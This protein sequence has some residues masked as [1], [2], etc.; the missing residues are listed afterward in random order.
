MNRRLVSLLLLTSVAFTAPIA[1]AAPE[2]ETKTVKSAPADEAQAPADSTV[3]DE[4]IKDT[5]LDNWGNDNIS[6][7][8]QPGATNPFDTIVPAIATVVVPAAQNLEQQVSTVVQ[9]VTADVTAAAQAAAPV[10]QNL[11][12]QAVVVAQN[13]VA[14]VESAAQAAAPVIQSLEQQAVVVAQNVAT[15][16][17]SAIS[18]VDPSIIPAAQNLAQQAVVVAQTT[19]ATVVTD[20]QSAINSAATAVA[21]ATAT[22][23][24]SSIDATTTTASNDPQLTLD[25]VVADLSTSDQIALLT[26]LNDN[27]VSTPSDAS[28]VVDTVSTAVTNAET[29]ATTAA[30]SAEQA[31]EAAYATVASNLPTADQ[32]QQVEAAVDAQAASLWSQ[33]KSNGAAFA[34]SLTKARFLTVLV[35]KTAGE[36]ASKVIEAHW[37][38]EAAIL[39]DKNWVTEP[40]VNGRATGNQV[41]F[42]EQEHLFEEYKNRTGRNDIREAINEFSTDFLEFVIVWQFLKDMPNEQLSTMDLF[43]LNVVANTASCIAGEIA[44]D[45]IKRGSLIPTSTSITKALAK[46]TSKALIKLCENKFFVS[47]TSSYRFTLDL[48]A[49]HAA[50]LDSR[51][52]GDD[53]EN[54]FKHGVSLEALKGSAKAFGQY[55]FNVDKNMLEAYKNLTVDVVVVNTLIRNSLMK[56]DSFAN[57]KPA[58]QQFIIKMASSFI[59]NTYGVYLGKLQRDERRAKYKNAPLRPGVVATRKARPA[60]AIAA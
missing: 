50:A 42:G 23:R 57:A 34:R 16:V 14:D 47:P 13:V 52:G 60:A 39:A 6:N 3:Q 58:T 43:A 46:G 30:S 38:G 40:P 37:S 36:V 35:A 15:D 10:I 56:R 26:A 32:V 31:A 59:R 12:Q 51:K 7:I 27:N 48:L 21:S 55:A 17:E 19:A 11:E 44:G 8:L 1:V 28:V 54:A 24:D 49:M 33:F 2:Q 45:L 41:V 25:Q 53:F 20:A 22:Q 18:S 9:D 5:V 29:Y 4:K